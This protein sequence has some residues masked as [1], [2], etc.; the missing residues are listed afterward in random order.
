MSTSIT[1]TYGVTGMTCGHCAQAVTEEVTAIEGAESVSIDLVVGGVSQV[2][3]TSAAPLDRSLVA[4]A[5]DEAGYAL[6]PAA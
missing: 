5:V 2:T 6:A 1:T 4:A 3:V